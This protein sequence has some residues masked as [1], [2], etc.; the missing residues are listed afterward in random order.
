MKSA[1]YSWRLS[2]ETKDALEQ[3]AR[4]R[5]ESLADLL[6]RI[7]SDWLE[8]ARDAST[9]DQKREVHLRQKAQRVFG[10]IAGGNPSRSTRAREQ[11]RHLLQ[12]KRGHDRQRPD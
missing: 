12:G 1:V 4:Q 5:G 7:T 6:D 11:L 9:D 8:L 2:P 3:E 10:S